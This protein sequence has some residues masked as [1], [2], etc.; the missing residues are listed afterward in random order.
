MSLYMYAC[1]SFPP[2]LQQHAGACCVS[3]SACLKVDRLK[4]KMNNMSTAVEMCA[5][6]S[7]E[8]VVRPDA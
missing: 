3:L 2:D 5:N 1:T 6:Y 8:N 4:C 7:T